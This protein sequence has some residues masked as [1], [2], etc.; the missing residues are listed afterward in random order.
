MTNKKISLPR[1]TYDL[2]NEDMQL[3]KDV[4]STLMDLAETF[5]FYEIQTPVFESTDLF[6]RAVGEQTDVISK[7]IY[8]FED[9]K[10]R[11]L[12]LRPEITAPVVRSFIENKMHINPMTKLS[13]YGPSFRYE[14][15]QA[16]RFR[17][18]NQFGIEC[19]APRNPFI[20]VEIISLA[21]SIFK[22]F[23]IEEHVE[24]KINSLGNQES[25]NAYIAKVKKYFAPHKEQLCEDCQKRIDSNPLRILDCKI[26]NE[27]SLFNDAPKLY[28]ALDS[29]SKKYF[30]QVLL[31]LNKLNVKYKIE[32]KLVRG[33]D[34]YN[35]T[36]FEIVFHDKKAQN[37]ILGGGRY[38]SL[39]EGLGGEATNAFGFA[40]GI[41]RFINLLV[42]KVV[43]KEDYKI[44]TDIYIMPL[45]ESALS[46]SF[47]FGLALRQEGLKCSVPYE[48]KT[49]KNYFKNAERL[50][51]VIAIIIG[52]EEMV[53]GKA[54]LKNLITGEQSEVQFEDVIVE[55]LKGS[56][57]E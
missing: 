38:D 41:E 36:I 7:E 17:Q 23:D 50:N 15:P 24:L 27:K 26:D 13:Y 39:V 44:T 25:R 22:V 45:C 20:D 18:F 37:A 30:D 9:K 31:E 51:A 2:F 54:K 55:I 28:D 56:N 34:Y 4:V 33:L 6:V 43:D 1:G 32:D 57:H 46:K 47:E 10:G 35:D 53:S 5:G 8:T 42:D 40:L 29:S 19:F 21:M 16:G 48:I 3:R 52:D 49:I 11:S 12:S 14:R